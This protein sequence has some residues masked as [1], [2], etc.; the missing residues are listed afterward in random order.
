[1]ATL[2][3]LELVELRF[4]D[5]HSELA[6]LV[7]A[8]LILALHDEAGGQ[9]GEAHGGFDLVDVLAA[10]AAGAKRV[11]AQILGLDD[12]VDAIV[13]FGDYEDGCEGSVAARL[14]VERR[15][16]HEAMHAAFT[17][18]HAVGVFADDLH[19]G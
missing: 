19:C 13:D 3:D 16:A 17:A 1:G 5:L 11:D 6:I 7:L 18:E 15:N 14:L 8:A 12:D 2:L 9:V 10:V 4:Q